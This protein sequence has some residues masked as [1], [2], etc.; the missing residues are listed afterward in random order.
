MAATRRRPRG[1]ARGA[2]APRDPGARAPRG[3]HHRGRASTRWRTA[4]GAAR[5]WSTA[6]RAAGV[7]RCR[8]SSPP[9][10]RSSTPPRPWARTRSSCTPATTPTPSTRRAPARGS[11][12]RPA[13][14]RGHRPR[15]GACA[16]PRGTGSPWPTSPTSPR[17]RHVEELNIGHAIVADAVIVGIADAVRAMRDGDGPRRGLDEVIVGLGL[18]VVALPRV[19]RDAPAPGGERIPRPGSSRPRTSGGPCPWH[20]PRAIEWLAGRIAAKE[21][22]SK[23]LGRARGHPLALRRRWSRPRGPGRPRYAWLRRRPRR[24]PTRWA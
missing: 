17:S 11:S 10:P 3:A 1:R 15:R 19:A 7:R 24:A 6:L 5:G 8:C 14:G 21:A 9:T 16:S 4:R 23:A 20:P 12:C 22:A 2:P 18:D 13:A